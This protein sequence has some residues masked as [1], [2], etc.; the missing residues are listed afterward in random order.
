MQFSIISVVQMIRYLLECKCFAFFA[1]SVSQQ[2]P[3]KSAVRVSFAVSR[4]RR[5]APS[6]LTAPMGLCRS[7]SIQELVCTPYR[8]T[9][10]II[11][12]QSSSLIR[13]L[14]SPRV[15]WCHQS[16]TLASFCEHGASH[17]DNQTLSWYLIP[18]HSHTHTL[19][20]LLAARDWWSTVRAR[21][22]CLSIWFSVATN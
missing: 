1:D 21:W 8:L 15:P 22:S 4:R 6:L 2:T 18:S 3:P 10:I 12:N 7:K 19:G 16:R 5:F 11:W 20:R 17:V 9:L 14:F 13:G